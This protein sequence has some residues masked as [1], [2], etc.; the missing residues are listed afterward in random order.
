MVLG[1]FKFC[2]KILLKLLDLQFKIEPG[3][4]GKWEMRYKIKKKQMIQTEP[5]IFWD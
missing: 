1:A 2:K 5:G 4:I 3:C